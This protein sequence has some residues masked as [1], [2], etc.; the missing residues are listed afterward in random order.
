VVLEFLVISIC[1]ILPSEGHTPDAGWCPGAGSTPA[2]LACLPT[3]EFYQPYE[4]AAG[5]IE[6]ITSPNAHPD[7][8]FAVDRRYWESIRPASH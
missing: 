1:M 8:P 7:D 4:S 6:N 5:A 3:H 2:K